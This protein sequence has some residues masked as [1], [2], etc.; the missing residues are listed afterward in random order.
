MSLHTS[1]IV[2]ERYRHSHDVFPDVNR[3]QPFGT[4]A[5]CSYN[6]L[7][8]Q[9]Y[10]GTNSD[11]QLLIYLTVD[12]LVGEWIS[13]EGSMNKY[14]VYER[15]HS[16]TPGMFGGYV[17]NNKIY[18]KVYNQNM[19]LTREEFITANHAYMTYSPYLTDKTES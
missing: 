7:D 11:F 12:N 15:E 1:L 18:R 19:G 3:T 6:S 16:I 9:I 8:L 13:T 2:T 10:N 14:E 4:G 17:R 5:T